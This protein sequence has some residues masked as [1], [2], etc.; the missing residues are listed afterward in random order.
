MSDDMNHDNNR[1][2]DQNT[3]Q[4][5]LNNTDNNYIIKTY[6]EYKNQIFREIIPIELL[7]R[8]LNIYGINGFDLS[9]TFS[10]K[11]LIKKNVP[12]KIKELEDELKPYYIPCKFKKY[13]D[14]I[15]DKRM[16]TILR[17]ILRLYGYNL[18]SFEKYSYGEK[19]LIYKLEHF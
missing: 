10:R 8:L 11:E 15:N 18:S 5:S 17:Q 6:P 12:M 1:D 2:T 3:H 13:F 14:N 9:H 4:N 16:I 7:Y 19:Y